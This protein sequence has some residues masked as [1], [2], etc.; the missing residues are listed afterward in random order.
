MFHKKHKSTNIF[1]SAGNLKKSGNYA[2]AHKYESSESKVKDLSDNFV[3]RSGK[4]KESESFGV[5]EKRNKL[6]NRRVKKNSKLMLWW[7][8]IGPLYPFER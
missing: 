5:T 3:W 7:T 2:T 4:V 8:I 6:G 1:I